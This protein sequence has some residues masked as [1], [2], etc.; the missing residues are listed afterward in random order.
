ME[1]K[2]VALQAQERL[3]LYQEVVRHG[4]VG[5]VTDGAVLYNG[6]MFKDKRPLFR[7]VTIQ[8][9]VV[10]P[11][12]GLEVARKAAMGLVT[13]AA[14]HLSLLNGM[15]GGVECFGPDPLVAVVTKI[16]LLLDQKPVF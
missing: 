14:S 1:M 10:Y 2:L 3:I 15:M 8:A 7:G 16:R 11:L 4:A 12:F 9:Q 13:L 6:R 5:P